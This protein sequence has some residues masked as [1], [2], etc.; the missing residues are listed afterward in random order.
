M[1]RRVVVTGMGAV[2]PLGL[3]VPELWQGILEAR[4]GVGPITL[5]DATGFD[6]RFAAEVKG[7]DPAQFMDRKEARRTDRF[8]QLAVAASKEALR[9]S[10]LQITEANRDEVGVFI[11]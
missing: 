3:S 10:E 5:F 2:S 8:V 4:N 11:A 6:T 9:S 7:F 1:E